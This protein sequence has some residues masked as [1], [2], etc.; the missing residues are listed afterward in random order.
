MISHAGVQ[1][2]VPQSQS[3]ENVF[4]KFVL[5]ML[6]QQHTL[7]DIYDGD[8]RTVKPNNVLLT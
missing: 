5:V 7:D 2:T 8:V 4:P 1:L 3:A 6:E